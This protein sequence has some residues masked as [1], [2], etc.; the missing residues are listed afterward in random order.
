[1]LFEDYWMIIKQGKKK[2]IQALQL[3][4]EGWGA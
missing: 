2:P 3:A 1:M 4:V